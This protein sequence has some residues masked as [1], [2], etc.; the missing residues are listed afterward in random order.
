MRKQ[1]M[2]ALSYGSCHLL[3]KVRTFGLFLQVQ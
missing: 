2:R 1:D 3:H